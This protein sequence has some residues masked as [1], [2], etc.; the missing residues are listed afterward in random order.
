M[1][2]GISLCEKQIAQII[3]RDLIK[4]YYEEQSKL[5]SFTDDGYEIWRDFSDEVKLNEKINNVYLYVKYNAKLQ[6]TR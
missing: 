2:S 5:Q 3:E 4:K 1:G 6:N